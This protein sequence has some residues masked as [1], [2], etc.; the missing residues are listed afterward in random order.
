MNKATVLQIKDRQFV[1]RVEESNRTDTRRI[2]AA[3]L[4]DG[5]LKQLRSRQHQLLLM[6]EVSKRQPPSALTATYYVWCGCLWMVM[7]AKVLEGEGLGSRALREEVL[8]NLGQFEQFIDRYFRVAP[9]L[10]PEM[11]NLS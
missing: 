2:T 5:R 1:V 11:D 10:I 3:L 6:K 4:E 8:R 7:K 9:R